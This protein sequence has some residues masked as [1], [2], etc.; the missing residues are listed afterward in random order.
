MIGEEA[1]KGEQREEVRKMIITRGTT[2]YNLLA[3]GGYHFS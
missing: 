1:E 2:V 3:I